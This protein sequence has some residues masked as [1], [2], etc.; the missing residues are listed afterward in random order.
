MVGKNSQRRQ[1][2]GGHRPREKPPEGHQPG[3]QGS[4]GDKDGRPSRRLDQGNRFEDPGKEPSITSKPGK[5]GRR[6]VKDPGLSKE[7]CTIKERTEE[8]PK[9]G[10]E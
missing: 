3:T 7:R 1:G 6:E 10:Q 2:T 4:V 8:P 5:Q 9:K